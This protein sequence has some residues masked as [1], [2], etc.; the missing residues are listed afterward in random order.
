MARMSPS[1][2]GRFEPAPLERPPNRRALG[3][4]TSKWVPRLAIWRSTS[5]RAPAPTAIMTMTEPTPMMMP[6][7]VNTLR[8]QLVAMAVTADLRQSRLVMGLAPS[9]L[10]RDVLYDG[11][12]PEQ[13]AA[14]RVA[15]HI[16]VVGDDDDGD[17]LAVELAQKAHDVG[18]RLAIERTRGLVGQQQ[19]GIV[20]ERAGD[21][22]ALLLATRELLGMVVEPIAEPDLLQPQPRLPLGIG[23]PRP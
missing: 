7:V 1:D 3:L 22:H 13:D 12:V 15:C 5:D 23:G 14:P 6:S 18:R 8:S 19:L 16:G 4:T 2:N 21:R 9:A 11:T 20:D 17:A 10:A